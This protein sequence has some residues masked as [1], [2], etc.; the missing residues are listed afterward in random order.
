MHLED[1]LVL[2]AATHAPAGLLVEIK[3]IAKQR[4]SLPAVLDVVFPVAVVMMIALSCTTLYRVSGSSARAG[5]EPVERSIILSS[6]PR[7]SQTPRHSG[8]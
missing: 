7:S 1:L 5:S 2:W 8:Q 6:S 4:P 3:E